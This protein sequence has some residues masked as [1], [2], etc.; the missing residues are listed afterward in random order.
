MGRLSGIDLMKE[1][2][3]DALM[4][5]IPVLIVIYFISLDQ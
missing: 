2:G 1:K 5:H 4:K 3:L